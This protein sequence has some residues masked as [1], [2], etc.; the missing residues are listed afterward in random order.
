MWLLYWRLRVFAGAR[1]MNIALN[2]AQ[3]WSQNKQARTYEFQ[4]L[5]NESERGGRVER[6]R[7]TERERGCA[8][9][10]DAWCKIGQLVK[11]SHTLSDQ[12]TASNVPWA[13]MHSVTKMVQ[14]TL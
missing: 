7:E 5:V 4:V 14:N 9:S 12:Q 11:V 13:A 10:D 1:M 2:L 8:S 3:F 6:E